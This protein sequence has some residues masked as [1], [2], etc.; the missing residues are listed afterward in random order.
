MDAKKSYME[1][2]LTQFIEENGYIPEIF[3]AWNCQDVGDIAPT[4]TTSCGNPTCTNSL[5]VI[6]IEECDN[7]D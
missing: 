1:R 5:V 6:T 3:T 4:L 2:K 7:N